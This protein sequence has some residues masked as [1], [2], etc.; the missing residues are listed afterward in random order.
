MSR[1][2]V[3]TEKWKA[4]DK[5]PYINQLYVI[6]VPLADGAFSIIQFTKWVQVLISEKE[7]LANKIAIAMKFQHTSSFW[8]VIEKHSHLDKNK[9]KKKEKLS[10]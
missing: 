9:N 10:C 7:S 2:D 4:S 1:I 8:I 5:V 3:Y 6:D